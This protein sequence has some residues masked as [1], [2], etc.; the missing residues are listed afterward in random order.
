MH[1]GTVLPILHLNGYKIA[2]PTVLARIPE[3]RAAGAAARATATEPYFVDGG[4]DG[5]D[6]MAVHER[7]AATMDEIVDRDRRDPAARGR[8][9][10][11]G[12]PVDRPALADAGAAHAEGLD[13]ARARSTA[14]RSRAP[15]GPTRCR[16]PRPA[17]NPEHLAQ[18]EAWLRSY[19]PEELF[20]DDGRA[21]APSS[22]PAPRAGAGG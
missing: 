7:M 14:C 10:A 3:R 15:G 20:D 17:K 8:Q 19:R 1:D 4:F 6:P 16:W 13:R 9:L 11:A 22:P 5:E 21:R 2:N 18:L 12:E